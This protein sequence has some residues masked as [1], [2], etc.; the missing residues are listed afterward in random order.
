MV[1][2]AE[3]PPGW[4]D[5]VI[6]HLKANEGRAS[7]NALHRA[8]WP[9]GGSGLGSGTKLKARLADLIS[10]G[11]LVLVRPGNATGKAIYGLASMIEQEEV[12][13]E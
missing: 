11:T 7:S 10:R 4:V 9:N 2:A 13:A 6:D 3:L 5:T 8:L 12:A 1:G